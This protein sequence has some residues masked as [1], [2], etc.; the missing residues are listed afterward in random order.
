[1]RTS[2]LKILIGITCLVACAGRSGSHQTDLK[3]V[4]ITKVVPDVSPDGKL[5]GTTTQKID[6]YFYGN[7]RIYRVPTEQNEQRGDSTAFLGYVDRYFVHHKDSAY[8]LIFFPERPGYTVR[9][10]IDFEIVQP[11]LELQLSTLFSRNKVV[12]IATDTIVPSKSIQEQFRILATTDNKL[13]GSLDLLYSHSFD[14]IPIHLS[15]YMDSIKG[16]KV[17][18]YQCGAS[19]RFAPELN[20]HVDSLTFRVWM[21]KI[22]NP[23]KEKVIEFA[24]LYTKKT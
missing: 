9:V 21:E 24:N 6:C 18:S 15:P 10:N 23:E 20:K 11:F 13:K 19:P 7:L 17:Y 3:S 8:G 14:D 2:V 16:N 5:I 22:N 12:L 1:M 4:R